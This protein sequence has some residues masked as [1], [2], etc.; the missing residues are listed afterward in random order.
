MSLL[1]ASKERVFANDDFVQ[2]KLRPSGGD[3][4][5]IDG[6]IAS[7]A[8]HSKL[9][10]LDVSHL[11]HCAAH[12]GGLSLKE[13]LENTRVNAYGS[14]A[15][16]EWAARQKIRTTFLSSSVIYGSEQPVGTPIPETASLN[17]GTV[18]GV[19]KVACESYLKVLGEGYG[20]EW[21]VLRLFATYGAGHLPNAF[22]GIIN[23]LLT[24]LERGGRVVVK[25]SLLRQRDVIH[26]EDVARAIIAAAV[27]PR[28][29][30]RIVNIGSGHAY[31]VENLVYEIAKAL[32]KKREDIEI[33]EE[34]GTVGDPAYNVG[35]C[36]LASDL[37]GFSP[38]V[39]LETGLAA[40]V[41]AR[42]AS[43]L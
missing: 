35:D 38:Q 29:I 9:A 7:S 10:E 2:K 8:F 11:V 17:P 6:D 33:V 1:R 28:T 34:E 36:R 24:Q 3:V 13:P 26:V 23:V 31:T 18:Y 22:Q 16:F 30:G 25:G 4:T 37:L 41:K 5:W 43:S 40:L 39:P 12:P 15:L 42:Q 32:G 14:M 20:L 19:N 21:T 27:S